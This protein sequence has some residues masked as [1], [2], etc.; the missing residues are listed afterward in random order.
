[1][2]LF[3]SKTPDSFFLIR[4]LFYI[5]TFVAVTTAVLF[6]VLD[7]HQS[8]MIDSGEIISE[9]TPIDYLAPYEAEIAKVLV[10]EGEKV[11]KGDTL[12]ILHNEKI[13]ADY[14]KKRKELQL[15]D[16]NI[17]ILKKQIEN[18]Q[19]KVGFQKQETS[20]LKANLQN[21]EKGGA[22]K[23][24][25]LEEQLQTMKSK[26]NISEKRIRKDLQLYQSGAISEAEYSE[27][28]KSY[29]DESNRYTELK[30]DY[31]QQQL[32]INNF[33]NSHSSQISQ[34]SQS[35]L[36]SE[37][38]HLNLLKD[39]QQVESNKLQMERSIT[40]DKSE[41]DKQYIIANIDGVISKLYNNKKEVSFVNKSQSML[42]LKPTA[43]EAFYAR[44]HIA[45][46]SVKDIK[47]DLPA[48][49]QLKAYSH[50]QYGILKGKVVYLD[51]NEENKF[52]VLADIS[53]DQTQ[54]FQLKSGYQVKGRIIVK[55]LKLY[56]YVFAKLFKNIDF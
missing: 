17:N 47:M 8:V 40:S 18:H 7:M 53:P 25:A 48:H 1:M 51:K 11:A 3:S 56:Q 55:K 36:N 37:S 50:Y 26:V 46:E 24:K 39:L 21:Q 45:E 31:L 20:H 5:M 15:I 54:D 49:I 14:E 27:K 35:I 34:N 4:T 13:Q 42:V 30:K 10:K 44:L 9:N 43:E 38:E 22:Y 52:Y 19:K 16:Q 32:D 41:I 6:F 12:I 33:G 28:Y 23:L 29:L 2:D